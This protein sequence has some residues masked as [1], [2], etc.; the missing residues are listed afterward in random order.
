MATDNFEGNIEFSKSN[1]ARKCDELEAAGL[2]SGVS[3]E[4]GTECARRSSA[5]IYRNSLQRGVVDGEGDTTIT[6]AGDMA[7]PELH[8]EQ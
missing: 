7:P 1:K 6:D 8:R 3:A 2:E 4:A 5:A